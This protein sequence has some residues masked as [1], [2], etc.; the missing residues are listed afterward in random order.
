MLD[1]K[2]YEEVWQKYNDIKDDKDI[3]TFYN[4][5][6]YKARKVTENK[7][8]KMVAMFIVV[9][10]GT[11][12]LVYGASALYKYI[13]Q[14]TS[15]TKSNFS[16]VNSN[17]EGYKKLGFQLVSDIHD[18]YYKKITDYEEYKECKQNIEHLLDMTEEDFKDNLLFVVISANSNTGGLHICNAEADDTTLYVEVDKSEK[19]NAGKGMVSAKLDKNLDRDNIILTERKE[20][21]YSPDYTPIKELPEDYTL[22]DAI[23]DNCFVIDENGEVISNNRE[24]ISEF[25]SNTKNGNED[26]IRIVDMNGV[27]KEDE[28]N[29]IIITDIQFINEMY[30]V[31][32]DQSRCVS[33]GNDED[34]YYNTYSNIEV[35][36]DDTLGRNYIRLTSLYDNLAVAF[37][38]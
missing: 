10:I 14:E 15:D 36:T 28:E 35:V 5:H 23:N 26:F 31:C 21:T 24:R 34:Y 37:Y 38:E 18:F 9:I 19:E 16:N 30:I 13:T 32:R 11:A 29:A 3:D 33:L 17:S 25:V 27:S 12:S 8:Y 20:E 6:Y 7:V 4:G 1:K 22:R 2:Y